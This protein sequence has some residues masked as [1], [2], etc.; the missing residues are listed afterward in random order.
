MIGDPLIDFFASNGTDDSGRVLLQI[1]GQSDEWLERTHDY[2]QWL[3]PLAERSGA[4]PNAPL[5]GVN[6][7]SLFNFNT[8]AQKNMLLGLDRML[9]FYGLQRNQKTITKGSNWYLRKDNW[10]VTPTHNDLRIARMLKSLS[11]LGFAEYAQALLDAIL[12]H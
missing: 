10:F 9:S 11:I 6:L 5:I 12:H 3:F 4:N 1:V 8:T 2:I 7:V